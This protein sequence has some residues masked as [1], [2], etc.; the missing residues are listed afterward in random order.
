MATSNDK[1][2]DT[3]VKRPDKPHFDSFTGSGETKEP[4]KANE[5]GENNAEL[6]GK[7]DDMADAAAVQAPAA[8]STPTSHPAGSVKRPSRLP[9]KA[10]MSARNSAN[11]SPKISRE[12]SP[13][14]PNLSTTTS[15]ALRSRKNSTD[16]HANG[17]KGLRSR[18]NS[19]DEHSPSR[20]GSMSGTSTATPSVPSAAAVQRALS[21]VNMSTSSHSLSANDPTIRAPNPQR[22]QKKP[23]DADGEETTPHWP[24]S[25]RLKS[26]PPPLSAPA[27]TSQSSIRK[28]DSTSAPPTPS[29]VLQR[30]I[31]ASAS[32]TNLNTT[33]VSTAPDSDSGDQISPVMMRS[34]TRGIS[35]PSSTL[36]TV[37][38]G[39]DAPAPAA[40]TRTGRLTTGRSSEEDRPEKITENP[41][42]DASDRGIKSA[43][44]SGTESGENNGREERRDR[45]PS[46]AAT[47]DASQRIKGL[48]PVK[49]MSTIAPKAKTG[50]EGTQSMTVETETVSSIPQVAVGGG[51]GERSATGRIEGGSV[52]L[53]RS[54]ETIRPKKEKK[55]VPRKTPSLNSGT[56]EM[57][58]KKTD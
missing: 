23:S 56:G 27:R 51:A 25:P 5:V 39:S 7:R 37:Q 44:E 1:F 43:P 38:E 49:S 28:A 3:S 42:E 14:R 31:P 20:S 46:K 30:S 50:A 32:A 13:I 54:T 47:I 33:Q 57:I 4:S 6:V 29:I 35:A 21:A 12:P 9:A 48:G 53:K 18:K 19:V 52:R 17:S 26:P 10:S 55:K 8:T 41:L 2:T 16:D 36:E 58:L 34:S 15:K 22:P 11:S 40:S 24:I 45:D